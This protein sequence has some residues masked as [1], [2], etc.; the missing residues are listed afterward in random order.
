MKNHSACTTEVRDLPTQPSSDPPPFP[1]FF[2]LR[3]SSLAHTKVLAGKEDVISSLTVLGH[4]SAARGRNRCLQRARVGV[5]RELRSRLLHLRSLGGDL[6]RRRWLDVDV[7]VHADW[8]VLQVVGG[9]IKSSLD[10]AEWVYYMKPSSWGCLDRLGIVPAVCCGGGGG[11]VRRMDGEDFKVKK[12][13]LVL[14]DSSLLA[15]CFQMG[16][17]NLDLHALHRSIMHIKSYD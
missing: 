1:A 15:F 3:E 8:H 5:L 11:E 12:H 4:M 13:S 7:F 9:C 17:V 2:P 10:M 6:C 16:A 14:F